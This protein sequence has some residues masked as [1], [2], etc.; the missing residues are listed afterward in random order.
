[1]WKVAY[2]DQ[3]LQLLN[4]LI[5]LQFLYQI[6]FKDVLGTFGV[7]ISQTYLNFFAFW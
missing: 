4:N 6:L 5:S 1:M 2:I 3:I 7:K